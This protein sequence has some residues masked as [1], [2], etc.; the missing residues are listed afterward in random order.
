MVLDYLPTSSKA[1]FIGYNLAIS[2]SVFTNICSR[3]ALENETV[4]SKQDPVKAFHVVTYKYGAWENS[5]KNLFSLP[6]FTGLC[7]SV[8][9][10]S[11]ALDT[12]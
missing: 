6:A 4:L 8:G 10:P 2:T 7:P 1:L 3:Q 12:R 11:F 9:I 5:K